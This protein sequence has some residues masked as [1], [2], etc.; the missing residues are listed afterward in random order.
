MEQKSWY[1]LASNSFRISGLPVREFQPS[2]FQ[3]APRDKRK[4]SQQASNSMNLPNRL[5]HW[6]RKS[7]ENI[8]NGYYIIVGCLAVSC[9]NRLTS[10]WIRII[11]PWGGQHFVSVW[12]KKSRLQSWQCRRDPKLFM[13]LYRNYKDF[14]ETQRISY[15][16]LKNTM[17]ISQIH[18][19]FWLIPK[20]CVKCQGH[21]LWNSFM[22]KWHFIVYHRKNMLHIHADHWQF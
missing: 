14:F 20:Y 16:T 8:A 9:V 5:P 4:S 2:L 19:L 7:A 1:P 22:Q 15:C 3:P 13:L 17:R 18:G 12:S 6:L 10:S 11:W 21:K